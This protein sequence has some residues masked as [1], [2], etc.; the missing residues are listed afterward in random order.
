MAI[1][2]NDHRGLALGKIYFKHDNTSGIIEA[3][4]FVTGKA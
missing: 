1:C 2:K 3:N 4:G